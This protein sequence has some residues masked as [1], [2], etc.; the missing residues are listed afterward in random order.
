V[1]SDGT[2]VSV[3][4]PAANLGEAAAILGDIVRNASFPDADFERERKRAEDG[5]SIALKDPG[6]LA[7]ML[8]APVVYG[9]APYGTVS[10]GTPASLAG[11]TRD[12]LLSFRQMW[13]RPELTRV[14]VSGGIDPAEARQIAA[15]TFGDWSVAGTAPTPPADRAGSVLPGRTLVVDLPGSGQASVYAVVRGLTRA[16]P[17]YYDATLANSILGG[18]STGRL[19]TE[20]R[21]KRALSYGAY[22]TLAAQLGEGTLAASAQ[23]KNES[24]ADVAKIFLDEFGRI[25]SE[26][27]DGSAVANRK[28][29]LNG[30]FQRQLQTSAGFNGALAGALLRGLEPGEAIAYS[31]RINAVTGEGATASM[32]KLLAPGRVSLVIVGDSA[33][34]IDPLRKIDP[35]AQVVAADRLDLSTAKAAP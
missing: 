6:A 5:L 18:S 24:A 31:D 33:K 26:P 3:T 34:F 35:N 2:Y 14:V 19:F 32:A 11:L 8:V 4:A 13:W 20:V 15:T 28:T 25:V 27:L 12:D 7:S 23:T 10:G 21:V 30:S 17:A 1:I 9:E 16:D 29:L 22:S